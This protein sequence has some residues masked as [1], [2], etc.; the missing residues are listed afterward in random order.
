MPRTAQRRAQWW[1]PSVETACATSI[2]SMVSSAWKIAQVRRR[3]ARPHRREVA[4]WPDHIHLVTDGDVVHV[5]GADGF[6]GIH[7][8]RAVAPVGLGH[9]PG[10]RER[11]VGHGDLVDEDVRV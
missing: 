8:R 6:A 10:A 3:L 4:V 11:A 2:R 1:W 9:G 7:N 5:V